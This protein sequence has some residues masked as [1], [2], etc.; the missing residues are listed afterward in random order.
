MIEEI[1]NCKVCRNYA[2]S[3]AGDEHEEIFSLALEKIIVQNPQNVDNYQSYFYKTLK[4]VYLDY[5]ESNKNMVFVDEYFND[6]QDEEYIDNY[7]LALKSFLSKETNNE[8]I[9]FYKDL[10]YLLFENS[11][12]S[13]CNKL[14]LRRS[15]LNV[16]LEKA[17]K[18]IKDEYDRITN[19]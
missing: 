7:K 2:K 10:I 17:Y 19:T 14:K 5:I 11:K 1:Y 9:I 12:L 6:S 4:C 15:D 18:L 13:L 3:I 8:E 16:Y